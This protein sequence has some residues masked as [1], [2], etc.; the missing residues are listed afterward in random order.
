MNEQA[1]LIVDDEQALLELLATVFRKEGFHHIHT[2]ATA[3]E[4]IEAVQHQAYAVI[5][6]DVMLP[7][8][9]GVEACPFIRQYTDAPIL[10]L[11]ARSTDFD[12]LS[13]FAVGGDDYVTKPFNPLEIVARIRSLLRRSSKYINAINAVTAMTP[14]TYTPATERNDLSFAFSPIYDFG[15]FQI[16]EQAAELIVE[17]EN[18]SCPPLVFQLLLFL[19][20]HPNRVFT[21]AELYEA[22]WEDTSIADDNTVMV[23]I[24]RIRERIEVNPAKPQFLVNVRGMGYKLVNKK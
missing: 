5:I 23:H 8:M 9:S 18:V 20:R 17:G 16:N 10:F 15:R 7:G 19:A 24:H 22:V 4:A 13:G 14:E 2:V 21:R 12:K 1:I 3:E 6:L 11:S